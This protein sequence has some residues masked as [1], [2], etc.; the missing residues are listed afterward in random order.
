MSEADAAFEIRRILLALDAS[1]GSLAALEAAVDLAA[2]MEAELSG[3]FVEDE[4]LMRM[5]ESPFARQVLYPA[6]TQTAVS[7]AS[8]EREM[9]SESERARKAL[10]SAAQRAKVRWSFRTVKGQVTRELLAAAGE[11]DVLA[12]GRVSWH[13]ARS[14][15]IGS[16]ALELAAGGV[17]LLL[18]KKER[19]TQVS[20]AAYFD[21]SPAAQRALLT[22]A[23]LAR[24]GG[25]R[26]TVFVAAPGLEQAAALQNRAAALLKDTRLAV[27][28]RR[29]TPGDEASLH[30]ALAVERPGLLV[31]AT[32]GPFR[33][34]ES[35]EKLLR[36]IDAPVLW[37]GNGPEPER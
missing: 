34:R 6:A 26:I 35:L 4:E 32:R 20:L 37:L 36:D 1:P 17:P 30:E 10:E 9:K 8:L 3:L 14:A 25:G 7:R 22:A 2:K 13:R 29:V 19:P 18:A 16:T 5:A 31:M 12:V 21:G 11:C 28:Y 24:A 33:T 27:G 15:R 23:Q